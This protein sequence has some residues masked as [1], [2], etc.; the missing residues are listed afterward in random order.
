MGVDLNATVQDSHAALCIDFYSGYIL[1]PI[2]LGKGIGIQEGS[3]GLAFYT[4]GVPPWATLGM[5]TFL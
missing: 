4:W 3:L 2:P 5:V 1:E